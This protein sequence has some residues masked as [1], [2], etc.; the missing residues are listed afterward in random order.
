MPGFQRWKKALRIIGLV[1]CV[2]AAVVLAVFF[3][4]R[5]MLYFPA[6]TSLELALAMANRA[7]FEPWRNA[8]GE[9]IGWK[10]LSQTNVPHCRVLITHGNAG[11]AID[12]VSYADSLNRAAPCDVYLL[13]YPG[14]GPR[15]GSPDEPSF[16]KAADEALS[17]LEREGPVHVVGESLGT[18]VAAFLAGTH[19]QAVAG[20]LLIAPYHNLS[21]VAQNHMPLFPAKWMIRDKFTSAKY[22]EKYHGPVAV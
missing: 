20:L 3:A 17:L 22:L 1:A 6:K 8:A 9:V 12:R 4:Q 5:R 14:Y 19:S 13:E 16:F 2:Y 15:D 10:R 21:D 7:G 11:C 18:G